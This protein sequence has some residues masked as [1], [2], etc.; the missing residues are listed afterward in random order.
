MFVLRII[1]KTREDKSIPFEEVIENFEI[2]ISYTRLWKGT[3]EFNE[4]M[5]REFP[6][7]DKEPIESLVCTELGRYFFIWHPNELR[8][9][10]YFIMSENGKT[11]ERM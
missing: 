1:E 8:V 6:E 10:D 4:I 7:A 9:Y 2:G 11:F 5:E 3:S